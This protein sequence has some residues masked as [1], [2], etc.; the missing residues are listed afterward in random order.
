MTTLR[1]PTDGSSSNEDLNFGWAHKISEPTA[2]SDRN[3]SQKYMFVSAPGHDSDTGRVYMYT[4]GVGADGST[5]DR[6]TQDYTI[7]APDGGSGQRFGHRLSAN[8]NGDILAV[9]SLAP[10]NA[11]KVEIFVKT[12]QSNDG[13]TQ[14][15]FALAQTLTGVSADGSSLNTAFGESMTMSK[16]G[17]V[18]IIGSPGVDDESTGQI[19]GGGVYYYKWNADGST[20]TY[21]LQQTIK[22]PEVQ[23]NMKFGKTCDI[24]QA[25]T[26]LVIGAE[27]FAN[28]K[29]IKFDSGETTFDLQDTSVIDMNTGSGG[30]FTATM[31]NTKFV[32]DDSLVADSVSEN[33]D[34]GKGVCIIDNTVLVGAPKDDGNTDTSDG[35]SKIAN[36]GTVNCYDLNVKGDYAWKNLATEDALID[37]DKLGQ[38]F[39][40]DNQSKQIRDYYE[41]YDPIKGRILGLADREIDIKTTWDPASYNFGTDT[42]VKTPWAAEHLGE[43]WW[44]LSKVKWIW[45]EQS[46]QEYKT[47]NWGKIFPGSSIDICEWTESTLLPSQWNSRANTQQG[48]SERIS[49]EAINGDDS[50]Y[51][52]IQRY[53]SRLNSLVN[54][55][56]YWVKNK[57]TVPINRTNDGRHV[58]LHR[59]NSTAFVANLIENPRA[60]NYKYYSVTDTNKFLLNNVSNLVNDNIVL[61]VDIRTN[62]FDGDSHSVWK[63][64]REGDKNYRPGTEI[65][66]RWWDS[67][68]GKN[69]AGDIVPD[70]DLP[71]NEK[72]GNSTRPRQS[73]YV[74]RYAALKELIDYSNTVLKKYQLSGTIN[75]TNLDAKDPEPTA[76]SLEWDTSID[77]YAELT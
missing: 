74:D 23:V 10:G 64:A 22:A 61:N 56:Y 70:L 4:W 24:N 62:T 11:G 21:T 7:D 59:K 12:S 18:L 48:V 38:V 66:S 34:F 35:S 68:I 43:V 72:Y 65:E 2:S 46:T 63:L 16:D 6:W 37:I 41:L 49:G 5:Y 52:V 17:T 3:T 54:Y 77:T 13:S 1:P 58:S 33:D 69:S 73:W 55:Y 27:N 76:Q 57:T 8:D 75:L 44:D 71:V 53:N 25:G 15:S 14:N 31:Y 51:T 39:E 36:D 19:D 28:R 40:F 42:N 26:R 32:I 50:K 9:S 47:N 45:Y 60:F 30:A 29:E 20:N 67:L